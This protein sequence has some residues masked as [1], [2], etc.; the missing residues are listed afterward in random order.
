L[1]DELLVAELFED[2]TPFISEF[3]N[4]ILPDY[5]HIDDRI[6]MF[7]TEV[8]RLIGQKVVF[9]DFSIS[10]TIIKLFIIGEENPAYIITLSQG[11]LITFLN[12]R[13]IVAG[14]NELDMTQESNRESVEEFKTQLRTIENISFDTAF[15]ILK[16]SMV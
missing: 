1:D 8:V 6:S 9:A 10:E 13:L 2:E 16:E 11:D 5:V 15:N 4:D 7:K 3:L 12:A 14:H